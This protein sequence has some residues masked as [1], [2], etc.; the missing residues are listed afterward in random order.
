MRIALRKGF[1]EATAIVLLVILIF[2]IGKL[3]GDAV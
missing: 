3:I 1:I 2:F